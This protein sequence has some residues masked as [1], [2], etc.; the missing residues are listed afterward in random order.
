MTLDGLI[1]K[2]KEMMKEEKQGAI[3]Y[4][5]LAQDVYK[6]FEP[7]PVRNKMIDGIEFIMNQEV[8]HHAFLRESLN[9]L[10]HIK[11]RR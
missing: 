3:A 10:I 6:S 4:K 7:D 11:R 9:T 5:K 2:L 1:S 8:K